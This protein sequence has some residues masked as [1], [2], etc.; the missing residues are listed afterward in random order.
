MLDP[1]CWIL[2]REMEE[3]RRQSTEKTRD[4]GRRGTKDEKEN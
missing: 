2:D 4:E 1:R 3:D